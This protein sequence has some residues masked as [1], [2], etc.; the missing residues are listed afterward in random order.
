MYGIDVICMSS[1]FQLHQ[2]YLFPEPDIILEADSETYCQNN[3]GDCEEIP[4]ND[5]VITC[6]VQNLDSD[7]PTVTLKV[8]G[9][10]ISNGSAVEVTTNSAEYYDGVINVSHIVPENAI[11]MCTVTDTRG[12]YSLTSQ[13]G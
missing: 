7:A 9:E 3:G 5:H 4:S 1:N 10:T 2:I 13:P 8:N 6:R 12:T 11:S